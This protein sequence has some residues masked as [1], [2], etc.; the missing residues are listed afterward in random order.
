MGL[1]TEFWRS[2][3]WRDIPPVVEGLGWDDFEGF[4]QNFTRLLFGLMDPNAL[5]SMGWKWQRGDVARHT[6][7][8]LA[9]VNNAF[10]FG[11]VNVAL[12][13]TTA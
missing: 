5:L 10:G 7:G 6:D 9:A 13:F 4:Q 1:S 3:F 8:D 12:T 11:G 2:G